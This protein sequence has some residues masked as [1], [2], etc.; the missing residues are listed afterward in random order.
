MSHFMLARWGSKQSRP[1]ISFLVNNCSC[2][3]VVLSDSLE[4]TL[5]YNLASNYLYMKQ[6]APSCNTCDKCVIFPLPEIKITLRR[7]TTYTCLCL[8]C[9]AYL[10][11]CYLVLEGSKF[12][13][14]RP[15]DARGHWG[16]GA[17]I[18][19]KSRVKILYLTRPPPRMVMGQIV[20]RARRRGV[21][22]GSRS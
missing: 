20:Y 16:A 12:Q 21:K 7:R 13:P 9:G 11:I 14:Q 1:N 2:T 3:A 22:S 19:G 10:R 17:T 8:C 5:L 4:R 6:Q 18:F 15:N